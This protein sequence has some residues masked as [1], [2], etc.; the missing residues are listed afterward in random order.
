MYE[1]EKRKSITA[2]AECS[3]LDPKV[4]L[5]LVKKCDHLIGKTITKVG[6]KLDGPDIVFSIFTDDGFE[7][8][9]YLDKN[10]VLGI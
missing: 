7:F 8:Y 10:K 3:Y 1:D 5:S 9:S 6:F 4:E 2:G